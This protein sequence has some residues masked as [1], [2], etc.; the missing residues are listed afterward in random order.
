MSYAS[1]TLQ[2]SLLGLAA[3]GLFPSFAAAGTIF[4]GSPAVEKIHDG[5][6]ASAEKFDIV[7]VAEGYRASEMTQFATDSDNARDA[8][9]AF[10]PYDAY[11]DFIRVWRVNTISVE[12]GADKP[13]FMTSVNTCFDAA[14]T[15]ALGETVAPGRSLMVND[16]NTLATARLWVP[17]VDVVIALVN[18]ST[19]GGAA[20][21]NVCT[22]YNGPEM[23]QV[24]TH[25]LGHAAI[26][27]ADEYW[28]GKE[29]YS[30]TGP[31]PSEPNVTKTLVAPW[32]K[33]SAWVGTAVTDGGQVNT[34][35]GGRG[36]YDRGLFR[37][38]ESACHMKEL[39]FPYCPVCRE[40]AIRMLY[41]KTD[42]ITASGSS[43]FSYYVYVPLWF[44]FGYYELRQVNFGT[45]SAWFNE[46]VPDGSDASLWQ[47]DGGWNGDAWD[48]AS[49]SGTGHA[50]FADLAPG[51]HQ[52]TAWI[53][54]TTPMVAI[55]GWSARPMRSVTW[56]FTQY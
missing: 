10:S 12:S 9:L 25:E 31:E 43:C 3:L 8:I 17:A 42:A 54:D 56:T 2:A 18:D 46:I 41:S 29:I 26:N 4:Y 32:C 7:F 34:W 24:V 50:F 55:G 14:Y 40:A 47:V 22:S 5:A 53:V 13:A 21:P 49:A 16:V 52:I 6:G 19:Y 28:S 23:R 20:R 30:A 15:M 51:T 36:K 44:G 1:R 37:P 39:R 35:E 27:L 48:Y 33:W 11:A 38:V 45:F